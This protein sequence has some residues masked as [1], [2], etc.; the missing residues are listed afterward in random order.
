MDST[1]RYPLG[2]LGV[3]FGLV[4]PP[5]KIT[6]TSLVRDFVNVS[7]RLTRVLTGF[8]MRIVGLFLVVMLDLFQHLG[9]D[10]LWEVQ[11]S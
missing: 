8:S 4:I 7:T 5:L 10:K 3:A 11:W 9:G 6:N 1:L 2:R